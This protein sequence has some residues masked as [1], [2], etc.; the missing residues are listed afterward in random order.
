MLLKLITRPEKEAINFYKQIKNWNVKK[1]E[2]AK[3]MLFDTEVIIKT[4]MNSNN[5][6]LIKN[7]IVNLCN[8]AAST[9]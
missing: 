5:N 4:K 9:S 3:K 7:L 8:K 2:E 6:T 1:L